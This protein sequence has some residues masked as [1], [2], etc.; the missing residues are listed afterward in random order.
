ME[1]KRLKASLQLAK[2]RYDSNPSDT[3]EAIYQQALEAYDLAIRTPK[4]VITY[5]TL[6]MQKA[7]AES[8]VTTQ[9]QLDI[10]S[11]I[12]ENLQKMQV[13][14][15]EQVSGELPKSDVPEGTNESGDATGAPEANAEPAGSAAEKSD[16]D[17]TAENSESIS[18]PENEQKKTELD[19]Q[20]LS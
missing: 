1:P 9:K 13:G 14:K 16:V 18:E 7:F 12:S 2:M 19:D 3:N 4:V 5:S 17:P 10:V 11:V 8:Q 20:P 15:I 6:A